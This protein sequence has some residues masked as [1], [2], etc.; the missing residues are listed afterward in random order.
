[1]NP[2]SMTPK[3]KLAPNEEALEGHYRKETAKCRGLRNNMVSAGNYK[4]AS[5]YGKAN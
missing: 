4:K 5:K 3:H 1:M 2:G